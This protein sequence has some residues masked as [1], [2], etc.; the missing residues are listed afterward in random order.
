MNDLTICTENGLRI[1]IWAA[2]RRSMS[3][4]DSSGIFPSRMIRIW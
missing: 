3:N 2:D 1:E 4:G